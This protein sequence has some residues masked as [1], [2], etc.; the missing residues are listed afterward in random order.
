MK[1]KALS[2]LLDSV[3]PERPLRSREV[4]CSTKRDARNRFIAV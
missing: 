2:F 3:L 4:I 1:Q